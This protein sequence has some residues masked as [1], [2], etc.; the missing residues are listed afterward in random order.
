MAENDI[1]LVHDLYK[2][3]LH[4][5]NIPVSD[6]L[7]PQHVYAK[8]KN[9]YEIAYEKESYNGHNTWNTDRGAVHLT[10]WANSLGAEVQLASDGTLGWPAAPNPNGKTDPEKLMGCAGFG[11]VNRSSDPR[12]G[13]SV[14][15][16]ARTGLSVA[17][18][19]PIGLYMQPFDLNGLLDPDGNDVGSQ[20]LKILRQ[21][22]DGK[23]VLRV[24]VSPPDGATFDLSDCKLDGKRLVFG[25]QIARRVTM[26]LYGVAKAIPGAAPTPSGCLVFACSYPPRPEFKSLFAAGPGKDCSNRKE[27]D[28]RKTDSFLDVPPEADAFLKMVLADHVEPRHAMRPTRRQNW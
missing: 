6:L 15:D 8:T 24:E 2:E 14:F 19:N 9:G 28:F 3:L 1:T 18:A 25:S 22:A 20:C 16:F 5:K 12:I 17:L 21:S 10:H 23:R 7:W 13:A 11:G 4:N 27:G 26:V